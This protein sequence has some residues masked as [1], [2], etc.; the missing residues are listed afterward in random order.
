MTNKQYIKLYN[1]VRKTH[2]HEDT[3][4][5]ICKAIAKHAYNI[6]CS[7]MSR[8]ICEKARDINGDEERK[9]SIETIS[10]YISIGG[11]EGHIECMEFRSEK[12]KDFDYNR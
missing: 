11:V 3:I 12:D 4:V 7:D 9:M 10:S 2:S 5:L 6:G 1:L 8:M